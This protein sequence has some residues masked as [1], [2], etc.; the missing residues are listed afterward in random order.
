[1]SVANSST[2]CIPPTAW[3]NTKVTWTVYK[4][5]NTP[6]M[7]NPMP[8]RITNHQLAEALKVDYKACKAK[9]PLDS[10]LTFI[11]TRVHL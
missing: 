3:D 1:V 9:V 4:K 2:G 10:T 5:L 8:K 6:T 7:V 11:A